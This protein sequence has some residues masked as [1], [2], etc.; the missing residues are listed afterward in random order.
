MLK[1]KSRSHRNY[2]F[3]FIDHK[4][5]RFQHLVIHV[6]FYFAIVLRN[7]YSVLYGLCHTNRIPDY[8]QHC[9]RQ[10]ILSYFRK[11]KVYMSS[12]NSRQK[13]CSA[14]VLTNSQVQWSEPYLKK[15]E[16]LFYNFYMMNTKLFSIIRAIETR[17][18]ACSIISIRWLIF[19]LHTENILL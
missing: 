19:N 11:K 2:R 5:L 15:C 4:K 1:I 16:S 17:I 18:N 8:T 12:L 13:I 9:V 6:P 14:E 10:R 7:I 3:N